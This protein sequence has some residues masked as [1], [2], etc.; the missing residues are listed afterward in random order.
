MD[1]INLIQY[2]WIH[3]TVFLVNTSEYKFGINEYLI[4]KNI[5]EF[6]LSFQAQI[7]I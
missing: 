1:I 3:D 2:I 5:K 6:L 4:N 7:F